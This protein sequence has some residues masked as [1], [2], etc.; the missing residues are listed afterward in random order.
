MEEIRR[1]SPILKEME[2]N[3]EIDIIGGMY[4]VGSGEVVFH[5]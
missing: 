3:G 4:D 2:D 1:R 5:D